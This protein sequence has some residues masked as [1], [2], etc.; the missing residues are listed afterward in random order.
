MVRSIGT[1]GARQHFEAKETGASKIAIGK[2]AA[3][4]KCILSVIAAT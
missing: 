1:D 2:I 3:K 4:G